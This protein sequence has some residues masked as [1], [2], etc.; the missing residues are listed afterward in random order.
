MPNIKEGTTIHSKHLQFLTT[1]V[2]KSSIHLNRSS[3]RRCSVRKGVLKNFSKFTGKHLCQRLYFNKAE[4]L[5][6]FTGIQLYQSL[7][8]DKVA[9]LRLW[10]RCFP[11]NFEKFLRTPLLQ[12]TPWRLPLHSN[13]LFGNTF[14]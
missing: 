10:H 8:F 6:K 1:E 3:H 4:G 2:C 7:Y 5:L 13:I 14:Q 12:N 9:G 11:M